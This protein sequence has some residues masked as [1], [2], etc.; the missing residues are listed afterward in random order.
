MYR[1]EISHEHHQQTFK[2]QQYFHYTLSDL[3]IIS[4]PL[5]S[6][7]VYIVTLIRLRLPITTSTV[8]EF[9]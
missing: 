7:V 6:L 9:L 2:D 3:H 8:E 4:L 5:L 1:L